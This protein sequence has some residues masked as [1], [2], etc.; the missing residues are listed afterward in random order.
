VRA[1]AWGE[2]CNM[3]TRVGG[4]ERRD[5]GCL[6]VLRRVL[7][8]AVRPVC[9]C[10]LG[11]AFTSRRRCSCLSESLCRPGTPEQAPSCALLQGTVGRLAPHSLIFL[12]ILW[13]QVRPLASG[14]RRLC[15]RLAVWWDQRP[16]RPSWCCGAWGSPQNGRI[17]RALVNKPPRFPPVAL[18]APGASAAAVFH[19]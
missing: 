9:L 12:G 3:E 11:L 2:C 6:A 16:C 4:R 5:T 19:S 8:R 1:P 17:A 13:C 7:Q 15:G 18:R 14:L 10:E